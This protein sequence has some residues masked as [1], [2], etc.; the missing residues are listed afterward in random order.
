MPAR[1]VP[2]VGVGPTPDTATEPGPGASPEIDGRSEAETAA[3]TGDDLHCQRCPDCA[4]RDRG[5]PEMN[6]FGAV[7]EAARRGYDYQHFVCPWHSYVPAANLIEE[8]AF[9]GVTFDGLHPSDCHL[10]EAKHGYDGF[11]DQDDWRPGGR[12]MLRE[13]AQRSNSRVFDNMYRQ[14]R[15]QRDAVFP[16]YPKVRLT[17]V[18]SSMTTRLYVFDVFLRPRLTPPIEVEVRSY[19][20]R[21]L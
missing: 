10:Y 6:H 12:P 8:W 16:H 13:W 17:W 3:K 21:G 9:S 2:P 18:F 19:Q 14:A 15:K 5:A 1:P 20:E 7:S 11:L 4:A